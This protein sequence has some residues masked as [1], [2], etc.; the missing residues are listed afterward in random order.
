MSDICKCTNEDCKLKEQC[1]RHTA[2][3]NPY[4]QP[5]QRYEP[6]EDGKCK[7]ILIDKKDER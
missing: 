5:T 1:R 7:W 3:S 4:Y 6:E 2:P